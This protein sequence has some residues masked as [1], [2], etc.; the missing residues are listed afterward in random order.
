MERRSLGDNAAAGAW[1]DS[2]EDPPGTIGSLQADEP[3]SEG[4]SSLR[5]RSEPLS[6]PPEI[7][8]LLACSGRPVERVA[9]VTSQ[10]WR[11][12][13]AAFRVGFADGSTAKAR[14]FL[15][16]AGAGRTEAIF[17]WLG[18]DPA[19]ARMILRQGRASLEEWVEGETLGDAPPAPDVAE[20]AGRLLAGWH[21]VPTAGSPERLAE[22]GSG[23]ILAR[24]DG[25]L[26]TLRHAGKLAPADCQALLG[27]AED[28]QPAS[29][30]VGVVHR[31]F[32]G[33]NLVRHP[34]RGLVSIDHEWMAVGFV[35]LDLA[36]SLERWGLT[37]PS[38]TAFL[39]GYRAV[40]GPAELESLAFWSLAADVFGGQLRLISSDRDIR[41]QIESIRTRITGPAIARPAPRPRPT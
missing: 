18:T 27:W 25:W 17:A 7:V 37:G 20:E 1:P 30:R 5:D 26:G 14:L 40:A 13:K 39:E 38:R 15:D 16:E 19:L 2:A 6:L 29:V 12:S 22:P 21:G 3:G 28:R 11:C 24:L 32:C 4:R 33:A 8:E 23:S 10:S 9:E 41:P 34:T 36:R 35:G 31:D